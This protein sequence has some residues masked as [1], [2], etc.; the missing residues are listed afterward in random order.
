MSY[1]IGGITVSDLADLERLVAEKVDEMKGNGATYLDAD[2][3]RDSLTH[4]TA[5]AR[6][7]IESG[8]LGDGPWI[9]SVSGHSNPGH[10]PTPG[11]SNDSVTINVYQAPRD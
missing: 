2:H 5:A 3:V 9:V 7:L 4:G 8:A 6:G 11:W 10:K 1:S